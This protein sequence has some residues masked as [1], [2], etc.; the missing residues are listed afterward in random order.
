[1]NSTTQPPLDRCLVTHL[2]GVGDSLGAVLAR[3][4]I[5]TVQDVLF[6][7]PCRYLDRTRNLPIGQLTLG[8]YAALQGEILRCD[9]VQGRRRSLLVVLG[10]ATG[11]V[12]LRYFHFTA[13]QRQQFLPGLRLRCFGE[14][15]LG[16]SGLELYHPETEILHVGTSSAQVE[17]LTPVYPLTEG[18]SQ[19][20]LRKLARQAVAQ[21]HANPPPELLPAEI[22]RQFGGHSLSDA[23]RLVHFPPPSASLDELIEGRHPCQLRLVFEELLA[24]HLALQFYRRSAQ[25]ESAPRLLPSEGTVDRFYAALPFAPT[26]AQL[27]VIAEIMQDLSA[28]QPMLRLVQGDVGSGKT[29]VAAVAALAALAN[30]FQVAVVAPTEILATQHFLNFRDWL[31]PLGFN[32][33]WLVG[34][35]GAAQKRRVHG[36]IHSGTAQ[37]VIGTHALF[38]DSVEFAQLGLVIIDEQHRFGVHQRLSLRQKASA[39]ALKP[40][41]LVMTATPI[42]RTLAMTYY[43]DLDLSVIDELPPG[44]QPVSTL[45]VAQQRREEVVERVSAACA[46]GRQ[47]YWVCTLIEDSETLSARAAEATAAELQVKL[48]G[49]QVGLVHG[50]L[51][52]TEKERTMAGFKAGEVQLLV[53]TTVIEVGVDVPN[54]SL[55]IIENPERLGLAQLHQ[56][57]GRVGRGRA[58]SH[59]VLLYSQPLTPVARERLTALRHSTDGF[60]IAEE[61]LRIRG[62]GELLGTRQTGALA[63]RLADIQKHGHLLPLVQQTADQLVTRRADVAIALVQRW[64]PQ[65]K[66]FLRG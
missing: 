11:R 7:L 65:G 12:G 51:K 24:H 8:T 34:K 49:V 3:L 32:V 20:R 60:V 50:R 54:A 66:D 53:A 23:L 55:M 16:A 14:A 46:E 64:F 15:R 62:P 47:V 31:Q 44:R 48:P 59:C 19:L 56:L 58:A 27:R 21:L 17:H 35:L 26:A 29:L 33:D 52:S 22:N 30:G 4:G 28:D 5:Y 57:R 43:A 45:L 25:R 36:D 9:L 6:H 41:Q 18:L 63:L 37:V 61:D 42:P 38:E 1:M 10:D 2:K 13:A 40:H 39:G